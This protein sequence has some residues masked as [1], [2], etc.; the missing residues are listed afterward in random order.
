MSQK[1]S[2][3]R[4]IILTG[5]HAGTTALAVTEE[6]IRR[7]GKR[8]IWDIYWIG[9]KRALE[10]KDIPT[11]E[12]N[13]LPKAGVK[14][15]QIVSGRIQRK[16]TLW[17]IPA[18][19]RIP[20]GF[21]H[22]LKIIHKIKPHIILSFGGF[23]SFPVVVVGWL[24]NIPIIV[25]EQTAIF[26]RANKLASMFSNKIALSRKSSLKYYPE[27]K[28]VVVGN[29]ILE[30]IT[31]IPPKLKMEQPPTVYITGGSRGSVNLNSLIENIIPKL[32]KLFHIVHQTGYLDFNKYINIKKLLPE[33]KKIRYEVYPVIDPM[34]V[35]SV[36][37]RA[38]IIVSRAGA[39]TVSEII[40]AKRPAILIPLPFAY[41]NEQFEN[42]KIAEKFGVAKVLMQNEL[43]SKKLFSELIKIRN[44]WE[45]IVVKLKN[46]KSPDIKASQILVDII[47]EQIE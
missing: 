33:N 46:K 5:S 41:K 3:V 43:N 42:A 26:G 6:L 28:S 44:N 25:H 38:D 11:I 27:G 4:R 47:E 17:T 2:K 21:I 45:K 10:G 12:S 32:L 20:I 16:F 13:V 36:F 15:H 23:A 14:F 31:N 7:S 1:K 29:P 18:L 22:A 34:E 8:I 37:K 35:E 9:T 30:N 19:F 24:L 40:A 39:N